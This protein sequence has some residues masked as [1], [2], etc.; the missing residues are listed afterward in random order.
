M[1]QW[2]A[3]LDD[4][5]AALRWLATHAQAYGIDP[6][7]MAVTGE[8]AGWHLSLMVAVLPQDEQNRFRVRAIGKLFGLTDFT[9]LKISSRIAHRWS[10]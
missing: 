10:H 9:Q 1:A 6:E 8:S 7:R 5:Q 3:Q 4:V 2:P